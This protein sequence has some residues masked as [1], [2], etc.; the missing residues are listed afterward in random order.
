M[1]DYSPL[2]V[3]GTTFT[4]TASA[5]TVGGQAL[6]VSGDGTVAPSSAASPKVVG[7]AAHGA[8]ANAV[9]TVFGR[10]TVHECVS[11]GTITAGDQVTSAA[12]GAVAALAASAAAGGDASHIDVAATAA[13]SVLG[14]AL[15]TA[16]GNRVTYMEV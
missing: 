11:T 2:Y 4:S 14:I 1:A 7:H 8:A 13:R 5:T 12:S 16:S 10:G 3:P 6:V 9:V 15:T